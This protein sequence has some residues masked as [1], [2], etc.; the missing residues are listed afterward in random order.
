MK[1]YDW[2]IKFIDFGKEK[3]GL[4]NL[5]THTF[6]AKAINS[7]ALTIDLG[8]NVGQFAQAISQKFNCKCY[9]IEAV[10]A[11]YAQIQENNLVNKFNCAI[12]AQNQPVKIYLSDN[13][14]CHSISQEFAASYGLQ[15]AIT[16]EGITLENFMD[17]HNIEL[18]DLLKVD[19]EGSEE[20]L[21]KST[22]DAMLCKK[23]KQ[24]TIEFHD[25]VPNSISTEAVKNIVNRLKKLGFF[26]IPFSYVFPEMDTCDFLFV[27][28]SLCKISL[29]DWLGFHMINWLLTIERT[30]SYTVSAMSKRL[31]TSA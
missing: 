16:V 19:I 31:Q 7:N 13:R 4:I 24:I 26:F 10:P 3:S 27:N 5:K 18:V 12:S 28:T 15:G 11:V 29:K 23:I 20:E 25:F 2:F 6:Y 9:A 17:S 21:F 30:K 1:L 22:S 8:A 14:E